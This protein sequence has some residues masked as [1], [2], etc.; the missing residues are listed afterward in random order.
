MS[1]FPLHFRN[2]DIHYIFN[3]VVQIK[4]KLIRRCNITGGE[5]THN[6]F[7]AVVEDK[8]YH[9]LMKSAIFHWSSSCSWIQFKLKVNLIKRKVDQELIHVRLLTPEWTLIIQ[10]L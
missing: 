7:S 1:A 3:I 8:Q 6:P 5:L 4:E 9:I 10:T 2:A